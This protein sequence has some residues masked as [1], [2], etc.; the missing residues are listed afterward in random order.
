[1][2]RNGQLVAESQRPAHGTHNKEIVSRPQRQQALAAVKKCGT[3]SIPGVAA[4]SVFDYFAI[5]WPLK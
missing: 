4:H 5:C 2:Y 3:R 1:M